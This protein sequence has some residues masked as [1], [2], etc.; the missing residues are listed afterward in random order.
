MD[1]VRFTIGPP[2]TREEIL[3]GQYVAYEIGVGTVDA[4]IDDGDGDP[5]ARGYLLN[6]IRIEC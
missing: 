2:A 4:G 5:A 1:I 3:S 6:R